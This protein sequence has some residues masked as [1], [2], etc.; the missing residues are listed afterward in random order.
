MIRRRF[1]ASASRL[2]AIAAFFSWTACQLPGSGNDDA[3]SFADETSD[4]SS[5]TNGVSRDMIDPN[6]TVTR[7]DVL[8]SVAHRVI[9]PALIGFVETAR[10]LEGAVAQYEAAVHSGGDVAGTRDAARQAF[11]TAMHQWQRLEVMQVGP[12]GAKGRAVAGEGLRDAI[13]SWPTSNPCRADLRISQMAAPAA[14][15]FE[16]NGVDAYGL[17]IVEYLLFHESPDHTCPDNVG[18]DGAWGSLG[19]AEVERRRA[20]FARAMASEARVQAETL[21]TRWRADAENFAAKLAAPGSADSPYASEAEALDAVFAAM[22][23]IDKSTKDLKLGRTLGII[24]GCAAPPCVELLEG[25]PSGDGAA[26]LAGNLDGLRHVILGGTAPNT[27]YGFDDL[28]RQEGHGEIADGLLADID[29]AIALIEQTTTPL[30]LLVVQDPAAAQALY[31]AIKAV[32]DDL[33]GPFVMALRL[34]IPA[35]G[36]GDND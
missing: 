26:Y 20:A 8:D 4:V 31:D 27:G 9:V 16:A 35:E 14:D 18:L 5:A 23:Y 19:A 10:S 33:K 29:A 3:D 24:A 17:D 21:S 7:A 28:L 12:A 15:Y 36:A 32:T 11:R 2:A 1:P 30:E 34:N 25:R 13:Y 6:K 22:F